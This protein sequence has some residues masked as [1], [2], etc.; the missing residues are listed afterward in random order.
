LTGVKWSQGS[1]PVNPTSED[2]SVL[3]EM[4]LRLG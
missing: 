1:N 2:C 3:L 4:Q